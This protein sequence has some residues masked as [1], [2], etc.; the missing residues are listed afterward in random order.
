MEN[1]LNIPWLVRGKSVSDEHTIFGGYCEISG[2]SYIVDKHTGK[3]IEVIPNTVAGSLGIKDMNGNEL[4]SNDIIEDITTKE[5]YCLQ[6]D[7][8]FPYSRIHPFAFNT[9]KNGML[10]KYRLISA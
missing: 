3:L 9:D 7:P 1:R 6:Y 10:E 5:V 4:F 2:K 8:R